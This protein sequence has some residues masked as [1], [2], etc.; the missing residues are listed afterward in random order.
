MDDWTERTLSATMVLLAAS[1]VLILPA[2]AG[3]GASLPLLGALVVLGAV[4]AAGRSVLAD[5]PRV[6]GH[7]VGTHAR[8]LWV[9]PLVAAALVVLV[10][11]DASP[12]ELQA[13]GGIAGL[14]GM[15]NYFIRPLYLFA[16]GFLRRRL[17][18]TGD[19]SA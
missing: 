17:A 2:L 15:I 16:Y 8:D 4:L 13:I 19:S 10:A 5:L 1:F 9:G 7:D 11:P 3:V 18:G 6:L 14:L 12:V